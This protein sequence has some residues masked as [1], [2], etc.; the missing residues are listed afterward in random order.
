MY[1]ISNI[2][3]IIPGNEHI[4]AKMVIVLHVSDLRFYYSTNEIWT[5][6]ETDRYIAPWESPNAWGLSLS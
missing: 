6:P 2:F 3:S 1:I 4:Q 5:G